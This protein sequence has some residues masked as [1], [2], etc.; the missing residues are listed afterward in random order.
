MV[1]TNILAG[2]EKPYEAMGLRKNGQEYPIRLEA[3]NIP[4]KG[5]SVRAVE[6]RPKS[7]GWI[8]LKP[9]SAETGRRLTPKMVRMGTA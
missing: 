4:Y 2:Y 5:Q 1:M 3:R 8:S 6:F 9:S 7:S